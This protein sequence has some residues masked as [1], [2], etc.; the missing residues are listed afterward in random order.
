MVLLFGLRA[1][2][3]WISQLEK[4]RWAWVGQ[5]DLFLPKVGPK[6]LCLGLTIGIKV[7]GK[8]ELKERAYLAV[9]CMHSKG[10]IN[11]KSCLDVI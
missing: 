3:T 6:K 11:L 5:V 4:A 8:R 1:H 7:I 9:V 10:K 2:G